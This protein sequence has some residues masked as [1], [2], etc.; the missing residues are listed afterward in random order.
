M[1]KRM[2]A[3]MAVLALTGVVAVGCGG[4][5]KETEAPATEAAAETEAAATEAAETDAADETEAPAD[6]TEAPADETEAES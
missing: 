2:L 5:K 3:L 1:K 6:E 4:A